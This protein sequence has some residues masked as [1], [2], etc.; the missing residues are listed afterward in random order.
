MRHLKTRPNHSISRAEI[1]Q[2]LL[3]QFSLLAEFFIGKLLV[4]ER[5]RR[6]LTSVNLNPDYGSNFIPFVIQRVLGHFNFIY[7]YNIA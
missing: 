5:D 3:S 1:H 6:V 7:D 4:K 2:A